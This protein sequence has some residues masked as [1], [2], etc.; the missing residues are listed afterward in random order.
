MGDWEN[1]RLGEWRLEDWK[2]EI[3]D[4]K[5]EIG[6]WEIGWTLILRIDLSKLT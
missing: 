1:G 3:G 2:L 4:W 5:L 6:Y